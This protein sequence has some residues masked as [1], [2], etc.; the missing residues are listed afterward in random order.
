MALAIDN[1]RDAHIDRVKMTFFGWMEA[2]RRKQWDEASL[3]AES[4]AL[5]GCKCFFI[6]PQ[7]LPERHRPTVTKHY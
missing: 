6:E 7:V 2:V 4:L 1:D 5:L 3:A